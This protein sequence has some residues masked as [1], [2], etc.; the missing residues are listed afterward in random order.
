MRNLYTT[1]TLLSIAPSFLLFLLLPFFLSRIVPYEMSRLPTYGKSEI[2]P[3][4]L[5]KLKKRLWELV[6]AALARRRGISARSTCAKLNP[7]ATRLTQN[8]RFARTSLS[9]FRFFRFVCLATYFLLKHILL[10]N[11]YYDTVW[12]H[13][14][15]RA[16]TSERYRNEDNTSSILIRRVLVYSSLF[17]VFSDRILTQLLALVE[18]LRIH[19]PPPAV[20]SVLTPYYLMYFGIE[21]LSDIRNLKICIIAHFL[22]FEAE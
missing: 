22:I 19:L 18:K 15:Y 6:S 16:R 12:T 17:R 1:H 5:T 20:V 14:F 21:I 4:R 8:Q 3:R 11:V 7:D 9:L 10:Y 13:K 2:S